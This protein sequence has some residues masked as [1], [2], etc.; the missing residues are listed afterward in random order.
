LRPGVDGGCHDRR[1]RCQSEREARDEN[2]THAPSF[3]DAPD[4]GRIPTVT[5]APRKGQTPHAPETREPGACGPRLPSVP[6]SDVP[7]YRTALTFAFTTS[8]A[9]IPDEAVIVSFW[10]APILAVELTFTTTLI[11]AAVPPAARF[12]NWYVPRTTCFV[13][14]FLPA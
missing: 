7:L 2:A 14:S 11:D 3:A 1:E 9:E 6:S 4:E 13:T 10:T 8:I 5:H 12:W